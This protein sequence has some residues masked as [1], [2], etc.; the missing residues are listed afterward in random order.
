MTLTIKRNPAKAKLNP[1]NVNIMFVTDLE[2][3][4]VG[5]KFNLSQKTLFDATKASAIFF[6]C[7]IKY[8]PT[9][10]KITPTNKSTI[11]LSDSVN[12][13]SPTSLE[14]NYLCFGT[15]NSQ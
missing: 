4:F 5:K 10:K 1:T 15:F 13:M 12:I 2:C 6:L 14:W 11:G 7:I 8:V 3:L 9:A